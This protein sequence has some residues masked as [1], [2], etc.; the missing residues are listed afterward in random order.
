MIEIKY[1]DLKTP[2]NASIYRSTFYF[3][4][5]L[6]DI[7]NID[8]WLA[9]GC[10]RAY[11]QR[12]EVIDDIDLFTTSRD[13]CA[14]LI[15]ALRKKGFVPY[16][17]NKNA[18]K[19]IATIKGKKY[20]I[21][22]VKKF[23]SDQESC[24]K[25]FDFSVSKFSL[26]MKSKKVVFS[27]NF[28]ADLISKRLVIPDEKYSNSLGCLKRL[29]KYI[30]KGY[31]ACNGTLITI[32]KRVSEVNFNDPEQNDIEFYPDGNAKILLFD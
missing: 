21:D 8:F 16:F 12:D 9:G 23:Y 25:D 24:I 2:I 7:D 11:F 32:A 29:Q 13:E 18:I 30:N 22:I 28:F 1:K 31:T 27:D 14:K 26:N 5:I 19:G 4:S 6:G 15:W 10:F 17:K 20:K 3:N